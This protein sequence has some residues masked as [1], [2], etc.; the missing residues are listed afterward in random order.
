MRQPHF[1]LYRWSAGS[2][3]TPQ[4][5]QPFGFFAAGGEARSADADLG[6]V[7][8]MGAV[9]LKKRRLP[10]PLKRSFSG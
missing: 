6:G 5:E 1:I 2:G 4:T 7:P 9:V 10:R 3:G 8:P